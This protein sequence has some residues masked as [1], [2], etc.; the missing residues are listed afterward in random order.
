MRLFLAN[1]LLSGR[2]SSFCKVQCDLLQHGSQDLSLGFLPQPKAKKKGSWE[3]AWIGSKP[4]LEKTRECRLRFLKKLRWL[5][6]GCGVK[7]ENL[8]PNELTRIKL[9]NY[10][11]QP[12]G[13]A[14]NFRFVI[15]LIWPRLSTH[16]IPNFRDKQKAKQK[17]LFI[18]IRMILIHEINV[19]ELRIEKNVHAWSVQF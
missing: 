10:S 2:F 17:L 16:L 5:I 4:K 19:F 6:G 12:K 15:F 13:N 9:I 7:H 1:L 18:Y 14:L 3:R 8:L 11:T